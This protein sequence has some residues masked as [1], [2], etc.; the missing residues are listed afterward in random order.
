M[1][2]PDISPKKALLITGIVLLSAYILF[3]ARFL[4]L[5][6]R[7][8]IASPVDGQVFSS[9]LITASGTAQ[10]ITFISLQDRPIFLDEKG[11]WQENLLLPRGR[12]SIIVKAR[13]RFGRETES[14]VRVVLNE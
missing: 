2:F 1:K 14:I 8:T 4:I 7:V 6:P 11:A 13:D 10:N 3:Q 12:S 5:G 9:A